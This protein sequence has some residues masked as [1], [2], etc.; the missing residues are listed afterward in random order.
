MWSE[1]LEYN[2]L[3]N[4]C[5]GVTVCCLLAFTTPTVLVGL[6]FTR[7]VMYEIYLHHLS[8]TTAKLLSSVSV[9]SH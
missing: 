5:T 9:K 2:L 4:M 6:I 3:D 7:F 8:T 1:V